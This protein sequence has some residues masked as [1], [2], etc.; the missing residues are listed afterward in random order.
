MKNK[1]V[2]ISLVVI[3]LGIFKLSQETEITLPKLN[4]YKIVSNTGTPIPA[5]LYSSKVKYTENSNVNKIIVCFDDSLLTDSNNLLKDHKLYKY[6]VV[7]PQ[8]K[9][10][11]YPE[12]IKT[13]RLEEENLIQTGHD[14]DQ[15][16]SVVGNFTFFT[17]P[18]IKKASYNEDRI[19]FNTYGILKQYGDSI[20]IEKIK[21]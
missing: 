19:V 15:F 1:I 20:I 16:T 11:G 18:P 6:L 9:M 21:N 14:A 17:D 3:I 7:V 5:I 13:F 10:I 4:D 8:L 2:V 12:K